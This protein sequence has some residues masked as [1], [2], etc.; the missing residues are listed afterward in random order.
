MQIKHD[1]QDVLSAEE[2]PSFYILQ[3]DNGLIIGLESGK[4][5]SQKSFGPIY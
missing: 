2:L 1:T 4:K 3:D 5:R